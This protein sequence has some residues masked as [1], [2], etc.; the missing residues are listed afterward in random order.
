MQSLMDTTFIPLAHFCIFLA[1]RLFALRFFY[2]E[3][4]PCIKHLYFLRKEAGQ[5]FAEYNLNLGAGGAVAIMGFVR[6][7]NELQA[8]FETSIN[9]M[10]IAKGARWFVPMK[11]NKLWLSLPNHHHPDL[12]CVWI[13]LH[14]LLC[15]SSGF[16][17]LRCVRHRRYWR[18]I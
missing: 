9:V 13:V 14:R 7:R 18:C 3:R 15:F 10:R 11:K 6:H 16:S 17:V 12:A 5:G 8:I 2:V 1:G 4:Y